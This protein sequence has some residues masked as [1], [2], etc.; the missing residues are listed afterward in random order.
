MDVGSGTAPPARRDDRRFSAASD[1][2]T[3]IGDEPVR[4]RGGK[5]RAGNVFSRDKVSRF[6]V[7]TW[8]QGTL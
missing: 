3:K 1:E 2:P 7:R 5:D 4:M 6:R 8:S